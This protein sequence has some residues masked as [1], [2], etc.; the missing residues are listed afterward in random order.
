ML[1]HMVYFSLKDNS[2][3]AR[4]RLIASC[5]KYLSGHEGV[6]LGAVGT[7]CDDLTRPVNV[8]DFDVA[9]QVVFE[10]RAAHDAYQISERHQTFMAENRENWRQV[11]VFDAN[12]E[13]V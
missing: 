12:V 2:P 6:T 7:V 5:K 1:G 13:S 8:L 11:R 3:E 9:L 10:N 4:L